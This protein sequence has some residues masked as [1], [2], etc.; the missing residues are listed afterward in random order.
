MSAD[1]QTI[2]EATLDN[3]DTLILSFARNI[4]STEIEG[5]TTQTLEHDL[6][7]LEIQGTE[8]LVFRPLRLRVDDGSRRNPLAPTESELQSSTPFNPLFDENGEDIVRVETSDSPW[9]ITHFAPSVAQNDIRI[10]PRIPETQRSPGWP[11]ASGSEPDPNVGDGF[12][13]VAGAEMDYEAPP[14]KLQTFGFRSG[15][16]SV[17]EYSFRNSNRFKAIDPTLKLEGKTYRTAPITSDARQEEELQRAIQG[18]DDTVITTWGTI[19]DA[20]TVTLPS[21]W[22]ETGAVRRIT[23]PYFDVVEDEGPIEER[24]RDVRDEEGI[25]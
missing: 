8:R 10:Y 13:Y 20:F 9:I 7:F 4:A 15:D 5:V 14:A 16:D 2:E 17:T 25:L 11:W 12:G 1:Y 3:G 19:S 21:E 24:T 22:A 18:E 23:G 6:V